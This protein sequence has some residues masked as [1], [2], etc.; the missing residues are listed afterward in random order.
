[1]A[2]S[3]PTQTPI[4]TTLGGSG[5]DA[6]TAERWASGSSS[7]MPPEPSRASIPGWATWPWHTARSKLSA[8]QK[9]KAVYVVTKGHPGGVL[10][11]NRIPP[12]PIP[13]IP[14]TPTAG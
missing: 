9:M 12:K 2:A 8:C 5:S 4:R 1:M 7:A 10:V 11:Q 6:K 13:A 3:T 14:D